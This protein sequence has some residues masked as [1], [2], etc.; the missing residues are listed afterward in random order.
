M[1]RKARSK[2]SS[3]AYVSSSKLLAC[4]LVWEASLRV[5]NIRKQAASFF[6]PYLR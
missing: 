5:S 4:G 2:V 3:A 6:L 1:K